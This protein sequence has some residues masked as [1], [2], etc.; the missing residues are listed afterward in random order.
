LTRASIAVVLATVIAVVGLSSTTEAVATPSSDPGAALLQQIPA[1][2]R[3]SCQPIGQGALPNGTDAAVA[4]SPH[5]AAATRV[6]VLSFADQAAATARYIGDGD[7]HKIP[8]DTDGDCFGYTDSESPFRTKDGVVG[9]VFCSPRDHSI[10]WTY[11]TIVARATG[12][13]DNDLYTWWEH[14]VGRTLN[15][16]QQALFGQVPGG[17][18]RTN[19]QDNG[20]ASIK[21]TSPAATVYVA[22]YTRLQ[23]ADSL[24]MAYGSAL[25]VAKLTLDVPRPQRR[26][27]ACSFATTWGSR[28]SNAVL[29]RVACFHNRDGT[30]HFLWTIDSQLTLVEAYGPSLSDVTQFFQAFPIPNQTSRLNAGGTN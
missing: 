13:N 3:T 29:G 18:N 17:T 11:G 15:A 8:R 2:L 22:K 9:R 19:C 1:A 4:C 7:K 16:T 26:K 24:M 10:E 6:L 28:S 21:C 27:D 25:S 23:T 12:P 30:Y 20:D 14:L 5:R